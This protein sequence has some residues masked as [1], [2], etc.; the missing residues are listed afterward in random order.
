M[1]INS[2]H[3][4]IQPA[5]HP[6]P[7][8]QTLVNFTTGMV[9]SLVA[10][11]AQLPSLL[12]SFDAGWWSALGFFLLAAIGAMS[13]VATYV[14]GLWAAGAAVTYTTLTLAAQQRQAARL[15]QQRQ[16]RRRLGYHED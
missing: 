12:A 15:E 3:A 10:F 2:V 8:P 16:E 9:V 4:D 6:H 13:V 1:Q 14:A 5:S 7:S 11:L